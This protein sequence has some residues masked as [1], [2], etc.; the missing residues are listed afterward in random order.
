MEL[1]LWVITISGA[2]SA[3]A[4]ALVFIYAC[5]DTLMNCAQEYRHRRQLDELRHLQMVRD[6]LNED[7][8]DEE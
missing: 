5:W 4:F 1:L 8:A 3:S 7:E 6:I 2:L